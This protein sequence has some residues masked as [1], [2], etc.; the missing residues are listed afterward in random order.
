MFANPMTSL[1][2]DIQAARDA[3]V[4][5]AQRCR[6]AIDSPLQK[7]STNA[8]TDLL[9][10][11]EQLRSRACELSPLVTTAN[12]MVIPVRGLLAFGKQRSVHDEVFGCARRFCEVAATLPTSGLTLCGTEV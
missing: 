2:P 4:A 7:L 1:P 9:A 3:V 11:I 12:D 5:L 10:L 6:S 8:V